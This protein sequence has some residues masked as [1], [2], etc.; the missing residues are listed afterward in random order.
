MAV[1]TISL[2][3]DLRDNP[4]RIIDKIASSLPGARNFF[5]SY[6]M[7][8][9]LAIMP[10]QLVQLAVVIPRL[11]FRVFWTRTPREFSEL[12][13]PPVLSLGTVYPQAI[14]I[15]NVCV[16]YSVIS[17]VILVFATLYF[18]I[19]YLVY[20]YKLLFVYYRPFESRGQAWP[21][22]CN[23]IGWGLIMCVWL[24]SSC[25][26]MLTLRNSFQI[27][28]LGLFSLRQ[29]FLLSTLVAPLIIF[30][31]YYLRRLD[32]DHRGHARYVNLYQACAVE[33]GGAEA[34]GDVERLRKGHPVTKSQTNLNTRRYE[35]RDTSLY[36]VGQDEHT[37]Y[38]QPPMSDVFMGVLDTGRR[39]YA[40]PASEHRSC[41]LETPI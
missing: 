17:P 31:I 19:A 5:I 8:Q 24:G 3:Q 25:V 34:D 36:I 7:L 23:R 12:N 11:I 37:D 21:A 18:G 28:M 38:A 26:R 33:D 16:T 14:L 32:R 39:R 20:K 13:A 1:S 30:T 2:L 35:K 10:L 9:G 6:V 15:F 29:A 41:R 4:G 27:F 40:H 22:A